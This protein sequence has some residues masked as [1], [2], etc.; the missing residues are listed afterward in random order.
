MTEEHR[1]SWPLAILTEAVNGVR[2]RPGSR[3]A[4]DSA[5]KDAELPESINTTTERP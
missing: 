3:E 4:T 2:G 1:K 5:K